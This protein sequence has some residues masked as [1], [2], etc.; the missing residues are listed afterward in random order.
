MSRPS[1][2]DVE[3]HTWREMS[4]IFDDEPIIEID[5]TADLSQPE[6][7]IRATITLSPLLADLLL[8]RTRYAVTLR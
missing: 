4:S 3:G 7:P 5:R 2:D 1:L 6:T 8:G